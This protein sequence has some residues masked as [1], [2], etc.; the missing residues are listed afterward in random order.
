MAQESKISS[1]DNNSAARPVTTSKGSHVSDAIILD[2]SEADQ[3]SQPHRIAVK[4]ELSEKMDTGK[5][6]DLMSF[7]GKFYQNIL[8]LH[9]H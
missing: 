9:Q 5:P 2:S 4:I 8:N 1:H 6:P 7:K 3:P